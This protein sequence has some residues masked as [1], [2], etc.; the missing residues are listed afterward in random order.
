M[1]GDWW[2]IAVLYPAYVALFRCSGWCCTV[3]FKISFEKAR[4][5]AVSIQ[6]TGR[7]YT[8]VL[9]VLPVPCQYQYLAS[10]SEDTLKTFLPQQIIQHFF[11]VLCAQT[12]CTPPTNFSAVLIAYL[13]PYSTYHCC[14][15]GTF[16]SY[17][18]YCTLVLSWYCPALVF[19]TGPVLVLLVQVLG[20]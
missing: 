13:V 10:S 19:C 8:S 16:F 18:W 4:T 12:L 1:V 5:T 11:Q 15:A 14:C 6:Y 7:E 9:P 20:T 3:R 17:Y 2:V